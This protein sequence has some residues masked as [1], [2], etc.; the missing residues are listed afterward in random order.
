MR[1]PFTDGYNS[2][3]HVV[4]GG[5]ATKAPIITLLF[6]VYQLNQGTL[7]DLIDVSEFLIGYIIVLQCGA[8]PLPSL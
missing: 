7:N 4:F 2:F 8:P 6:I 3:W 1:Y 5:L